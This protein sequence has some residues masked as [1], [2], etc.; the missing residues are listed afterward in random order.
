MGKLF[1]NFYRWRRDSPMSQGLV[2]TNLIES[3][4]YNIFLLKKK[5]RLI[6]L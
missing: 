2:D 5:R 3:L 6:P 1:L 4:K